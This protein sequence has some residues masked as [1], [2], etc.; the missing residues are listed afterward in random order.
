MGQ[1]GKGSFRSISHGQLKGCI[2]EDL[3]PFLPPDF[4]DD[5][6][7]AS[8]G[9][10]ETVIKESRWRWAAILCLPHGK[11]IF[12]KRDRTKGWTES[13][14]YALSRSKAEKEWLISQQLEIK[15]IAV[16]GS[17][18]WMK[19]VSH[20]FVSESYYLSEAI[21]SGVS[22]AE[23]VVDVASDSLIAGLA[24]MVHRIHAAGL[25]HRDLHAGNFLYDGDSLFL[26][27]LHRAEIV[28]ALSAG[29]RTWNVAQLF[30]SMRSRWTREDQRSFLEK[31]FRGWR[32]DAINKEDFLGAVLFQM[33]RLQKRQ[34]RSRTKRCVKEST[35]FT[36]EKG[37][38]VAV[39]RRR[40]FS[41][42]LLESLIEEGPR[43]IHAGSSDLLKDSPEVTVCI[44][45]QEGN[46]ICL[47]HFH[48]PSRFTRLKERFRQSRGLRAWIGG[49]GLMVRG[50]RCPRPFA[51]VEKR[52][53]FTV[54]EGLFFM[55][56]AEGSQELDRYLFTGFRDLKEKRM[57]IRTCAEW[58]S[59]VHGMDVFH[60][61]LKTCNI[62][63]GRNGETWTF[64]LLDLEDVRLNQKVNGKRALRNLVQLNASTP[65]LMTRGD[66]L[67]FLNHYLLCR[68]MP[69]EKR[70]MVR[71]I[72]RQSAKRGFVYVSPWGVIEGNSIKMVKGT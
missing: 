30:H 9:I 53:W 45:A 59:S 39:Y 24:K 51:L 46:R 17:L 43:T 54:R 58:L 35:D 69:L 49:N 23:G 56:A 3:V 67:R 28:R 61:D 42:D 71:E 32:Q 41:E 33:D 10:R 65:P 63:V 68:P 70:R 22:L 15:E 26:T 29:Q 20:G 66:R 34:W 21:G 13:L 27:D 5:P 19:K 2:H 4:F 18:G 12:L 38:G 48:Y 36:R 40:D 7:L 50:I 64:S 6:V 47:K 31:Y 16:P 52:D 11:R 25:F 8:C 60:K 55:E 1:M 62:L 72:A 44:S 14:K 37:N 57:F